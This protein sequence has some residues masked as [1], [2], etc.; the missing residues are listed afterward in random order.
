[1][2]PT[3]NSKFIVVPTPKFWNLIDPNQNKPILS[4]RFNSKTEE[5]APE[6]G[7]YSPDG[8]LLIIPFEN[9]LFVVDTATGKF[10][11]KA[12]TKIKNPII[13]WPR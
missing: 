7:Y 9:T 13:V 1:M 11:G 4:I 2:H 12:K 3:P 5:S 10:L 8:S 6:T